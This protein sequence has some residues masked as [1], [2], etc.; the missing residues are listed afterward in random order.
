MD[1]KPLVIIPAAGFGIRVGSPPAKEL[2]PGLDGSPLIAFGLEQARRRHWPV[3]VI[4]RPEKTELIQYLED[5]SASFGLSLFI[6]R[7]SPQREWPD[8]ILQSR[9]FWREKNILCLPDTVFE[10][11]EIWDSLV[12]SQANVSAAVFRPEDLSV[13]GT[14]RPHADR[15][16]EICDKPSNSRAADLAWGI[17]SWKK[18]SGLELFNQ[19]SQS[20][21]DQ[22]WKSLNSIYEIFELKSF[23]DLTRL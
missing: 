8:T 7:I 18:E 19:I 6:Q 5:Y 14:L 11:V 4:T 1:L 17:L 10:P 9:Q 15:L 12:Q 13:W 3:H 23:Q 2:L 20:S 16:L 21:R 22:Q